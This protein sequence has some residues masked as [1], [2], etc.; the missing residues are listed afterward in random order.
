MW[1]TARLTAKGCQSAGVN[2]EGG[3]SARHLDVFIASD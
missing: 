3:A 2:T 1:Y